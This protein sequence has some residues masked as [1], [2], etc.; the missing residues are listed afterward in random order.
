MT[1][2]IRA[3]RPLRTQ[4]TGNI[5]VTGTSQA[6]AFSPATLGT[7]AV[8]LCN[9]GTQTVFVYFQEVATSSMVAATVSNGIPLPS[10]QTEVFTLSQGTVGFTVIAAA[11]GS[12]LY[13]N[14]GEGL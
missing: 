4:D 2:Q 14:L 9:I 3:F 8:R 7:M 6:V 12:T 11:T 1:T 10:G 13:Y 5:V